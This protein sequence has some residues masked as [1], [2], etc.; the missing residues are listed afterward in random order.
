[1]LDILASSGWWEFSDREYVAEKMD[2]SKQIPI[3]A[4]FANETTD[5]G[6]VERFSRFR[7]AAL[8]LIRQFFTSTTV[9]TESFRRFALRHLP[10][11]PDVAQLRGSRGVFRLAAALGPSVALGG[12]A[13][14]FVRNAKSLLDPDLAACIE[15]L[16]I[17]L[18]VLSQESVECT[19]TKLLLPSDRSVACVSQFALKAAVDLV[20]ASL[21]RRDWDLKKFKGNVVKTVAK[22]W[23][24][25]ERSDRIFAPAC[26]DIIKVLCPEGVKDLGDVWVDASGDSVT[27]VSQY[28]P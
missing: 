16:P 18:S 13:V 8:Q 7:S 12:L 20:A 11:L 27:R 22:C 28:Q 2:E 25:R 4:L 26:C 23:K 21:E 5:I 10:A 24:Q 9:D 14:S 1:M 17:C 19:L 15:Y 3:L 6:V